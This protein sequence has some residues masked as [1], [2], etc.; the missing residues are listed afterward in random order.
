M[1]SVELGFDSQN[2][3]AGVW[4][5]GNCTGNPVVHSASMGGQWGL[6]QL[7]ANKYG[8]H[9]ASDSP[10]LR[11]GLLSPGP[12]LLYTPPQRRRVV[13]CFVTTAPCAANTRRLSSSAV[14]TTLLAP[15][16]NKTCNH[17]YGG[18]TSQGVRFA[19]LAVVG[20]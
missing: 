4:I 20:S 18:E 5:K 6:K 1:R 16:G 8:A 7:F 15:S 2:P 9:Q 12:H 3:P 17:G 13:T 19:V 14:V 10:V 11:I